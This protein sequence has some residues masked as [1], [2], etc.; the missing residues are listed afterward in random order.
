VTGART[1]AFAAL[2][3][4]V[5]GSA[6]AATVGSAAD[7]NS[8]TRMTAALRARTTGDTSSGRFY[9]RI[10]RHGDRAELNFNF[11]YN[12]SP[13]R[14][15]YPGTAHIHLGRPGE[16]GRIVI[17]LCPPHAVCG[18]TFVWSESFRSDLLDLMRTHGAYVELHPTIAPRRLALVGEIRLR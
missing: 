11:T 9:A 18:F 3:V 10:A 1:K 16:G 7:A 2:A 14:W 6:L 5:V 15:P 8:P 17:E 4:V 12:T 13:F